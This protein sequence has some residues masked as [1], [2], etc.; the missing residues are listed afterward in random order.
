MKEIRLY[1]KRNDDICDMLKDER[2]VSYIN[3]G[4]IDVLY[5]PYLNELSILIKIDDWTENRLMFSAIVD[6]AYY[7][8]YYN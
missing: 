8:A 6:L 3:D 4:L 2:F 7:Y 5:D 1:F